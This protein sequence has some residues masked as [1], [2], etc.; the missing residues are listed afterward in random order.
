MSIQ[1]DL[2]PTLSPEETSQQQDEGDELLGQSSKVPRIRTLGVPA[3]VFPQEGPPP[4]LG[5]S[6]VDTETPGDSARTWQLTSVS[7][8]SDLQTSRTSSIF[9][10]TSMGSAPGNGET[11]V[12][13]CG[14]NLTPE[15]SFP[16]RERGRAAGTDR[17]LTTAETSPP[18]LQKD[19]TAGTQ[20]ST[21]SLLACAWE[22]Q[23][24][25]AGEPPPLIAAASLLDHVIVET[26]RVPQLMLPGPS[27]GAT[28]EQQPAFIVQINAQESHA[29]PPQRVV[30]DPGTHPLAIP[31][32]YA[33][34]PQ[35]MGGEG[36]TLMDDLNEQQHNQSSPI[37]AAEITGTPNELPV[38]RA[39]PGALEDLPLGGAAAA[40]LETNVHQASPEGH[41]GRGRRPKGRAARCRGRH[42][43]P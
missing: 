19:P 2:L 11:F 25:A 1:Q 35:G 8:R 34:E 37:A 40:P 22:E 3:G 15:P 6:L 17:R 36:S 30:F 33:E 27:D 10:N 9:S 13:H 39:G 38:S 24:A 16:F 5:P 43:H 31:A 26:E 28:A 41:R 32:I 23:G 12:S 29:G 42:N 18:D 21:S 20:G 7:G 14:R 4:P